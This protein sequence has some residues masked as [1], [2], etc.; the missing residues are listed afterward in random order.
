[1]Y[2]LMARTK[3]SSRL[4]FKTV[5]VAFLQLSKVDGICQNYRPFCIR[6]CFTLL[7]LYHFPDG[8]K[9]N[10]SVEHKSLILLSSNSETVKL[11]TEET[12]L[13]IPL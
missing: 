11:Q 2:S 8:R 3:Y 5:W 12:N 1:M 7:V 13:P 6:L 9:H 10:Y 4:D